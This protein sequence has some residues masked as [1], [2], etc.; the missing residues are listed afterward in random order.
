MSTGLAKSKPRK[1][2]GPARNTGPG[3]LKPTYWEESYAAVGFEKVATA[4]LIRSL[5]GWE[6]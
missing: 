6:A 5:I 1:S 3:R 2:N 4:L